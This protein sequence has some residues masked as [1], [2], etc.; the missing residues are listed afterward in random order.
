LNQRIELQKDKVD[1]RIEYWEPG[2]RRWR[3]V[4]E[5]EPVPNFAQ[6]E[7]E[8]FSLGNLH[9]QTHYRLIENTSTKCIVAAVFDNKSQNVKNYI[10]APIVD[11]D[12]YYVQSF[13]INGWKIEVGP[14]TNYRNAMGH[15]LNR[16]MGFSQ[17]R[18]VK[19]KENT[20]KVMGRVIPMVAL[21]A[22]ALIGVDEF[23]FNS[24]FLI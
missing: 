1:F 5:T 20:D 6:S 21:N 18:L 13:S 23:P 19:L 12:I 10:E 9:P 2:V 17:V 16:A 7:T 14:M 8:M 4:P 24:P 15:L 22:G 11:S 3:E